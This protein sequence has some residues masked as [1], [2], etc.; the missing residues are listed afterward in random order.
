MKNQAKIARARTPKITPKAMPAWADAVKAALPLPAEV[1]DE[2]RK[3]EGRALAAVPGEL[4][5][6]TELGDADGV[7]VTAGTN[8]ATR[9]FNVILP[10]PVAGSQPGPAV[11]PADTQQVG[12][13]CPAQHL[14]DPDV[15]SLN[16]PALAYRVGWMNPT[17]ESPR[18]SRCVFTNVTIRKMENFMISE[19]KEMNVNNVTLD[20]LIAA[21]TGADALVPAKEWATPFMITG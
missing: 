21:A 15:I 9:L 10:K 16:R 12:L 7:C 14:F 4:G 19:S 17:V 20:L 6:F 5:V 18:A 2:L 3:T 1:E 11:N 13:V 8:M